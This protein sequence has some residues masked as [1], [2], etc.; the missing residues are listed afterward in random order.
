[1]VFDT[2]L[3][4]VCRQFLC[5][6]VVVVNDPQQIMRPSG[7]TSCHVHSEKVTKLCGFYRAFSAPTVGTDIVRVHGF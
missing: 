5:N 4:L 7:H 2:I 6:F 1:M 3:N